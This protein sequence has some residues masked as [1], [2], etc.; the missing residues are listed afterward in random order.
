M[1]LIR[2]N[3]KLCARRRN[4]SWQMQAPLFGDEIEVNHLWIWMQYLSKWTG[5][6]ILTVWV[7]L[8]VHTVHDFLLCCRQSHNT[9]VAI[10]LILL[11]KARNSGIAFEYLQFGLSFL[12]APCMISIS[13]TDNPIIH[14]YSIAKDSGT[15]PPFGTQPHRSLYYLKRQSE[16]IDIII[17]RFQ[18]LLV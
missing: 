3:A 2:R 8:P 12:Y 10:F 1:N 13:V 15:S 18:I 5:K 6:P 11:Y 7:I 16:I 14:L 4:W 17:C 9:S